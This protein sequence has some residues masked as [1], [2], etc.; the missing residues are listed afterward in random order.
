[1][2]K[3][4]PLT[5]IVI[6]LGLISA[7]PILIKQDE[8]LLQSIKLSS[9]LF[10]VIGILGHILGDSPY[11]YKISIV[12]FSIIWA[13]GANQIFEKKSM[14]YA[15]NLVDQEI[16]NLNEVASQLKGLESDTYSL[17]ISP[18]ETSVIF[19]KSDSK[20]ALAFSASPES[21]K[22]ISL[23]DRVII[24]DHQYIFLYPEHNNNNND[25]GIAFIDSYMGKTDPYISFYRDNHQ[26]YFHKIRPYWF[27]VKSTAM[28]HANFTH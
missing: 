18:N 21:I 28:H 8:A 2:K 12:V 9:I 10:I 15:T 26:Y 20:E 6:G 3:H 27:S 19:I 4:F 23:F 1:M 5:S 13:L 17:K 22:K 7:L 14:E 24:I 11:Q 25:E 16:A